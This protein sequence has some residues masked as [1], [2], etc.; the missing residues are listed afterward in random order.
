MVRVDPRS[1]SPFPVVVAGV[2]LRQTGRR[3][4]RSNPPG[5]LPAFELYPAGFA[6][7]NPMSP[8]SS[9]P[10]ESPVWLGVT[11][12]NLVPVLGRFDPASRVQRESY[13]ERP[14]KA[15]Q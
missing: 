10:P 14:G 3:R 2:D 7:R 13:A 8:E 4:F 6:I 15:N 12:T 5:S 1:R 9:A 11:A